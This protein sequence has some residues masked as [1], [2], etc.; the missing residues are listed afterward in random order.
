VSDETLPTLSVQAEDRVR[1]EVQVSPRASRTQR[2]GVHDGALKLALKAPPVD[3]AANDELVRFVAKAI[4]VPRRNVQL[5]RGH[6]S[7]RKTLEVHTSDA[8]ERVRAWLASSD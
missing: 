1:F 7:K 6:T 4:G 5:V 2:L 8:L 3:G